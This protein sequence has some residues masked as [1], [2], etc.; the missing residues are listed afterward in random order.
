MKCNCINLHP[1]M[2]NA[3]FTATHRWWHSADCTSI[4]AQATTVIHT[5]LASTFHL[6]ESRTDQN[7]FFYSAALSWVTVTQSE[8]HQLLLPSD[9][10][11]CTAVSEI[12]ALFSSLIYLGNINSSWLQPSEM[13]TAG[14]T[15]KFNYLLWHS[16]KFR[17][18][19][20]PVF[21]LYVTSQQCSVPL[22]TSGSP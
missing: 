17:L 22:K 13:A 14:H 5:A 6:E 19:P 15:F 16:D 2:K 8:L 11:H 3:L 9:N 20:G 18:A 1:P 7:L 10:V 4:P 21:S 12:D